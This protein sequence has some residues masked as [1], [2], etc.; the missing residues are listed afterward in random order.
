[1]ALA[2]LRKLAPGEPPACS[3]RTETIMAKQVEQR[4]IGGKVGVGGVKFAERAV[5]VFVCDQYDVDHATVTE[6]RIIKATISGKGPSLVTTAGGTHELEIPTDRVKGR[7]INDVLAQ[8]IGT[9]G[10]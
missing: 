4:I 9:G 3:W 6:G 10:L 8:G 5:I 1:M 7:K 2:D